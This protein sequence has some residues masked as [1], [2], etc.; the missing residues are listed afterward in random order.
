MS[1]KCLIQSALH[2]RD[3][4][5]RIFDTLEDFVNHHGGQILLRFLELIRATEVLGARVAKYTL[6]QKLWKD[7]HSGAFQR[8]LRVQMYRFT[9]YKS[10]VR[11]ASRVNHEFQNDVSLKQCSAQT[12]FAQRIMLLI[13]RTC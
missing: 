7:S 4:V 10:G 13:Q 12:T 9:M 1:A 11:K 5:E 8:L 3:T 6:R 2:H